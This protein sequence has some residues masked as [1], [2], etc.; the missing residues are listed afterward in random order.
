MY[1]YSPKYC[2]LSRSRDLMSIVEGDC[3]GESL[4]HKEWVAHSRIFYSHQHHL[5]D[6]S[7]SSTIILLLYNVELGGTRVLPQDCF[8]IG[9]NA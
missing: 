9:W 6:R 7:L 4:T 2:T 3:T 1:S 5:Y 8:G